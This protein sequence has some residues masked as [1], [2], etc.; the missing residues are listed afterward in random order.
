MAFPPAKKAPPFGKKAAPVGKKAPPFGKKPAAKNGKLQA[1][2]A[3]KATPPKSAKDLASHFAAAK[4]K[5]N[6]Y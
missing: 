6:P 1:W 3:R 2:A 4:G 5:N